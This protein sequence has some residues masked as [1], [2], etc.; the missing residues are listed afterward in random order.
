MTDPCPNCA[1]GTLCRT[2]SC[3][4]LK[5]RAE[6]KTETATPSFKHVYHFCASYRNEGKEMILD[7]IMRMVGAIETIECY[8]NAKSE[9]RKVFNVP[10]HC[11]LSITN[12]SFLGMSSD[13]CGVS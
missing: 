8:K 13:S 6:E 2:P 11:S 5:Q 9:L 7:G 3:G 10:E 4:R 1:P 12:L